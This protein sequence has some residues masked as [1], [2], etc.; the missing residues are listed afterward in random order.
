M[1]KKLVITG[2][3]GFVSRHFLNFLYEKNIEWDILG[4]DVNEPKY[5]YSQ[6]NNKLNIQFHKVDLL[7]IDEI[8]E[9]FSTFT[10]DYILHLASFSSVSYSWKYPIE[11]FT[12]N[13]NIFL[14]LITVVKEKN[15]NCRI[16]SVGSSEEY[17]SVSEI[18]LPLSETSELNP[19]SPYAVAR[20]S[21]EM[22]SKV[23]ADSYHLNI[24]MTRSFNHIGPWQD[25]RFVVSSFINKILEIKKMG[26]T[27]GV[28]ETG[29]TSII[30]DFVDVRDVVRAYYILLMRGMSGE[31][32][33]VC[34]GKE[35]SL[36]KM[37]TMIADTVGVKIETQINT[38]FIR[39]NDNRCIVG[40]FD[41]L[42]NELSWK[43]N[44][45]LEKTILDI[46]NCKKEGNNET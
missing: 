17:G 32:Y 30:R 10:P 44:I 3:A 4:L 5:E 23:F 26:K 21:Q 45:P 16:L 6:F 28:I 11:S 18:D 13:T 34:S 9:V 33:N 1:K 7:Q 36:S 20:V 25:E 24:I 2:F 31:V 27:C 15:S 19:I 38:S 43:P 22:L 12:N 29:D 39:P 14:N 40:C 35:V 42:Y 41:K 37:I 8:R 46:I